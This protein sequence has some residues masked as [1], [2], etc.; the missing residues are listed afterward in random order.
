M[1]K[2]IFTIYLISLVFGASALSAAIYTMIR[3]RFLSVRRHL[4]LC[5]IPAIAI[6]CALVGLCSHMAFSTG[7]VFDWAMPEAFDPTALLTAVLSAL[8]SFAS[9]IIVLR[10]GP[11]AGIARLLSENIDVAPERASSEGAAETPAAKFDVFAHLKDEY[12]LT[13]REAEL[14][15]MICDGKS[16]SEIADELFISENTV[17]THIYNLFKKAEIKSRVELIALVN[18]LVLNNETE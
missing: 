8:F 5:L 10:S 1:A 2:L 16:N 18:G 6:T 17:K 7:Y 9:L 13:S 11:D 14:C 15:V 12:D 3:L 4:T